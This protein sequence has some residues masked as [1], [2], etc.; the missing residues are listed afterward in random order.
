MK[1]SEIMTSDPVTVSNAH[2]LG[3]VVALLSEHRI[4]GVPVVS[5]NR[6]VGMVTKT[7][8]INSI[9]VYDKVNKSEEAF[10]L[11]I[12]LLESKDRKVKQSLSRMMNRKVSKLKQKKVISVDVDEDIYKSAALI[13]MHSI[14][15]LPVTK[16]GKLV[17][18]ISK[19][20]IILALEK[21][22]AD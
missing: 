11:I 7:D 12:G 6:L 16:N 22:R 1:V 10:S 15:R 18:I 3:D 9:N 8:I 2:T 19:T 5:R 4:S 21:W 14:D 17:G 13:N 20:D